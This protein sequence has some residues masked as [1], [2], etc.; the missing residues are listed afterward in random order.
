MQS[1]LVK[2]CLSNLLSLNECHVSTK[3]SPIEFEIPIF[4]GLQ[5]VV[6]VGREPHNFEC[7]A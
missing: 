7:I 4:A 2:T 5:F 1:Y 3:I 6:L